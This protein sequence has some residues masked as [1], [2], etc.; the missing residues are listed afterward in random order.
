MV[1]MMRAGKWYL[2]NIKIPE[3][4]DEKQF[5]QEGML[6]TVDDSGFSQGYEAARMGYEIMKGLKNPAEMPPVAPDPGPRVLNKMRAESLKIK[7]GEMIS[8]DEIIPDSIAL[9]K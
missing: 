6:L 4:S 3:C 1:D 5:V 2:E 8:V 7:I 9:K